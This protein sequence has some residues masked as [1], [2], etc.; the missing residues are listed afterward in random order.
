MNFFSP[1][2]LKKAGKDHQAF[3]ETPSIWKTENKTNK[4]RDSEETVTTQG[5]E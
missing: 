4:I 2:P 5:M 3:E 1:S